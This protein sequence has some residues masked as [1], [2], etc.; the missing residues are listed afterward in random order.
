MPRFLISSHLPEEETAGQPV[1]DVPWDVQD[2]YQF[3]TLERF[4]EKIKSLIH[5][6]I[7]KTNIHLSRKFWSASFIPC[8][9]TSL[10]NI[11]HT[12]PILPT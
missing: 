1:R 5:F 12:S 3:I 8:N 2:D 4:H 7:S 11:M 6:P 10:F 9:K